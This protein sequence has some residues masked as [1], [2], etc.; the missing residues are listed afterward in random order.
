MRQ[1]RN[2]TKTLTRRVFMVLPVVLQV[3]LDGVHVDVVVVQRALGIGAVEHGVSASPPVYG[4]SLCVRPDVVMRRRRRRC[5]RVFRTVLVS[6]A[7]RRTGG[8]KTA[9][10]TCRRALFLPST[11]L[12]AS[13][14][15]RRRSAGSS[16]LRGHTISTRLLLDA[17]ARAHDWCPRTG[18]LYNPARQ[19]VLISGIS[20]KKRD[21]R[22]R[23]RNKNEEN[24]RDYYLYKS[25]RTR[26]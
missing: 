3:M 10:K 18:R 12:H 21:A 9:M 7:R 5:C 8:G 15:A 22:K 11:V 17:R 1:K 16:N 25:A 2:K 23:R 26:V 19:T 24:R 14:G 13:G 4:C 20:E 6:D